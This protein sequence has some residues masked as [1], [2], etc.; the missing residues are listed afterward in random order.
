MLQH[1]PGSEQ[2]Y[3]SSV[4]V[5]QKRA[6]PGVADYKAKAW[7]DCGRKIKLD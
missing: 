4:S 2:R 6:Y 5:G 3:K 7:Y 1:P